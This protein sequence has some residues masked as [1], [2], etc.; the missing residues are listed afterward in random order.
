MFPSC[1]GHRDWTT[2]TG[3]ISEFRK[4][5]IKAR[6]W[7]ID[8]NREGE[9]HYHVYTFHS[10]RTTFCSILVNNGTPI[11]TAKLLMGHSDVRTT[12]KHYAV[13]GDLTLKRE[14]DKVFGQ[15]KNRLLAQL[16]K[17]KSVLKD[18]I[19]N[20]NKA[21]QPEVSNHPERDPLQVLQIKLANGDISVQE[22]TEKS[23]AI[24]SWRKQ[25]GEQSSYIG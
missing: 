8:K 20:L 19:V 18:D 25:G 6:L 13:L 1:V 2:P 12:E 3:F 11:Y 15:N 4:H 7:I 10:F 17:E 5:L 9:K 24:M 21:V 16:E 22:F 14:L 23:Q